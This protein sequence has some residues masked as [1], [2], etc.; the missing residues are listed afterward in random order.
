MSS[1]NH[2]YGDYTV[3]DYRDVSRQAAERHA[4]LAAVNQSRTQ[5]IEQKREAVAGRPPIDIPGDRSDPGDVAVPDLTTRASTDRGM[6][7]ATVP[8]SGRPIPPRSA[9]RESRGVGIDEPTITKERIFMNSTT[10]KPMAGIIAAI[11]VGVLAIGG[12]AAALVV[13]LGPVSASATSSSQG[14]SRR[15]VVQPS[16]VVKHAQ[17]Q[18]AQLD[19]YTGPIDGYLNGE[20]GQAIIDLQRFAYLP[21]T[22][23]LDHGTRVAL[24]ELVQQGN[25]RTQGFRP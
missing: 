12:V 5:R 22:G 3:T 11:I 18:L 25:S 16:A 8:P 4:Q 2:V 13:M 7:E 14:D 21:E 6:S 10:Q 23:Q 20:T 17:E 15:V 19:Y 24:E 9:T 1:T